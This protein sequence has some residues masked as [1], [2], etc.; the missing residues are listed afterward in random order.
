MRTLSFERVT[1]FM[2][3][4]GLAGVL[5][6]GW[7]VASEISRGSTCPHLLGLPACYIVFAGY[8]MATVGAWWSG[9]AADTLFMTGAFGVTAI[10]LYFS[11]GQLRGAVECPTFEGLP[12]SYLSLV[13]GA[14]LVAAHRVRVGLRDRSER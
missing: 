1:G 10:G 2:S 5:L 8:V 4:L 12:M 11:V 14:T 13:A 9:P 7:L 6:T 3:G